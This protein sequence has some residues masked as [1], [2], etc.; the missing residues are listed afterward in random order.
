MVVGVVR[1]R[2]GADVVVAAVAAAPF[3]R[4]SGLAK[5]GRA[6]REAGGACDVAPRRAS[7]GFAAL[8]SSLDGTRVTLVR[9]V[10]SVREV[11]I[12][13]RDLPRMASD[14]MLQTRLL[15]NNPREVTEVDALEIYRQAW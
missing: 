9:A 13:E 5:A 7:L 4:L 11:G 14:A 12:G 1:G 2:A 15:V 10:A 3:V 6:R 8:V